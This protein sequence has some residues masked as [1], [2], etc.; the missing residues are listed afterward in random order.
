MLLADEPTGNL[1]RKTAQTIGQLLLDMHQQE[2]T[3]LI[4]NAHSLLGSHV[5][6]KP[7]MP[8]RTLAPGPRYGH[9]VRAC[10]YAIYHHGNVAVFLGIA[11]G[12]AVLTGALL[13]GDSLRGSLKALTLDQ[14]GWVEEAMA[15]GRF[16]REQLVRD[17]LHPGPTS[18]AARASAALLLQGSAS[19]KDADGQSGCAGKVAVFGIEGMTFW[20]RT[21]KLRPDVGEFEDRNGAVLNQALADALQVKAGDSIALHLQKTD[22]VSREYRMGNRKA[23]DVVETITPK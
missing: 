19:R 6:A 1:D 5:A 20:D 8:F 13:V 7:E 14:L 9:D 2:K 23:E 10:S 22:A 3:M 15:P 11:F 21:G 18:V 16:F 12:S 17:I 4:V